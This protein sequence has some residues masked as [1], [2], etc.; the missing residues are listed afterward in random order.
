[1]P[2]DCNALQ[3]RIERF[4]FDDPRAA[5]PF[6]RR[7]ARENRWSERTTERVIRE[8]KRFIV[9]AVSAD[10][11]VTPS[12]H[13]DQ[14]WHLHI[15]YTAEY[16]RF[17]R[18]VLG[19]EL[20]H[21]PSTGGSERSRYVEDYE[22]TLASYA[23][24]FREAPP[25]DL[26]PP[27]VRRFG[28]DLKASR[29]NLAEH[30]VVRKP[31]IFR[32]L[33]A[34]LS[35]RP[36][37]T[38][39]RVMLGALGASCVACAADLGHPETLSGPEFLNVYLL[40]WL[41]TLLAAWTLRIWERQWLKPPLE[42]P[43]LDPY[44]VAALGGGSDA[45]LDTAVA[46]LVQRGKVAWSPGLDTVKSLEEPVATKPPFEGDVHL[47]IAEAG[48]SSLSVLR[49]RSTALARA[50]VDRLKSLDL[51]REKSSV[52]PLS[53]ALSA[54]LIGTARILSRL[55]TGKPLGFLVVLCLLGFV[56]AFVWFRRRPIRTG[57]GEAILSELR[58][59]HEALRSSE[60]VP[61]LASSGMLPLAVGLFGVAALDFAGADIASLFNRPR[62]TYG[63]GFASSGSSH[64]GCSGGASDGGGGDGGGGCGGDGG[65]GGCGGGGD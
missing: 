17:C 24:H 12:E 46:V 57:R 40:L 50:V 28:D 8:Y 34:L 60:S 42:H 36:E 21:T 13:V 55:G 26:W 38:V 43:E 37:R 64:G 54:P 52:V 49:A 19:R 4:E 15:T 16:R 62:S 9:L 25:S 44:E 33:S 41:T 48:E 11:S 63:D 5:D 22:R 2:T 35:R 32:A 45:A 14:A 47:A 1:M 10:H 61:G 3:E 6:S 18:D 58:K 23:S 30:W 29:V 27:A 56:V 53:F 65:C 51:V 7:L 31:R 39:A 20:D 59:R